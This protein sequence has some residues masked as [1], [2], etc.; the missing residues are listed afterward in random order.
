MSIPFERPTAAAAT[1][2]AEI[3]DQDLARECLYR[4]LA[5]S[6][7]D[8][9]H[10]MF[11]LVLGNENQ[12]AA[13]QAAE[14]LR[15]NAVPDPVPLG[16]GERP[17]GE[18]DLTELI[19]EFRRPLDDL[20]TEYDR[21]FGLIF[22]PE[23]PPYE[24]EYC[25]NSEP[26]FRSQQLADVAGFY[27]AFGLDVAESQPERPDH[28]VLELEFM[29]LLLTKER[30]ARP[31]DGS[32]AE[33]QALI[34]HNA[35]RTFFSEHLIWWVPSFASGLRRKSGG[36]PYAAVA[37]ALAAFFPIERRHY[38]VKA[39]QLPV[40]PHSVERPEEQSGCVGCTSAA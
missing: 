34:C 16:F 2:P 13:L 21:T 29:A 31:N 39:P 14:L 17:A 22:T 10:S 5:A 6:L 9:R 37:Q 8:P 27:R 28:I 23:C 15:D 12:S 20:L 36:G 11:R 30:L 38:G 4:F 25:P 33:E 35:Q 19:A 32:L 3:G 7:S 24:T 40:R 1:V 18:R 26:F